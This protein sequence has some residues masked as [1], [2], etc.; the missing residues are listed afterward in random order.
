M[1]SQL[2]YN[3]KKKYTFKWNFF[4][5]ET[6]ST[7]KLFAFILGGGGGEGGMCGGVSFR[8]LVFFYPLNTTNWARKL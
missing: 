3:Q 5:R 8:L 4:V 7:G 1:L 2:N 6:R